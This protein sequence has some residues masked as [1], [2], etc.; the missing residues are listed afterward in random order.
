MDIID[1]KL[2]QLLQHDTK[3]TTKE[4][5][6]SLNLSV[7]AIYERIKKLERE[8]CGFLPFEIDTTYQRVFEQV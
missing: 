2:L 7:T 5:S 8:V 3:K 6:L 4:L 1:K